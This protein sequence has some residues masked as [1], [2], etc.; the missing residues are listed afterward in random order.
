MKKLLWLSLVLI[1]ACNSTQKSAGTDASTEQQSV[2]LDPVEYASTIT[3]EDLK[4]HLYT[5]ASDEFEGRETGKEGEWRLL[6]KSPAR[7]V[8]ITYRVY[9]HSRQRI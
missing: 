6:S 5:Y 2:S 1:W 9:C 4:D 7:N 3:E 8:Q